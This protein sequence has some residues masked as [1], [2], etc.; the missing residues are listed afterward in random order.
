[1]MSASP[2]T[3]HNDAPLLAWA[4][5]TRILGGG[6]G[7]Q[8]ALQFHQT[9]APTFCARDANLGRPAHF[10]W[11]EMAAQALTFK[12]GELEPVFCSVALYR[13]ASRIG[14]KGAEVDLSRS[15]RVSE[16]FW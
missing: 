14:K 9:V 3:E 15:G 10:L 16:T 8:T 6:V 7:Q 1:M 2:V 4:R 11:V 13:I 12:V 5:T